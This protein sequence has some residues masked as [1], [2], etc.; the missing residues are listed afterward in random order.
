MNTIVKMLFGSHL[1]GTDTPESD[2]DYKGVFLPSREQVLL[3]RIPEV[4]SSST[5]KGSGKNTS[6]DVDIEMFSLHRFIDM[7]CQG[8]TVAIDMLHAPE[9]FWRDATWVW[10]EIVVNR[11]RFYTSNMSAFVQYARRQA[12]KYGIKGSRL[13]DAKRVY[14]VLGSYSGVRVADI[15]KLLPVGGHIHKYESEKPWIYEVCGRKIQETVAISYAR[16]IIGKFIRNYGERARQAECNEGVDW[17]AVSHALRAAYQVWQILVEGTITFPL[18]KAPYLKKVKAGEL[19]YSTE[20]APELDRMVT[21][22]EELSEKSTL[23]KQV[24]REWWDRF[25]MDVVEKNVLFGR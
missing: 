24:D 1:Y 14:D 19:D 13:A 15:W 2:V 11:S 7:A 3:G 10:P 18:D 21:E 5:K 22:I 8:Q 25:V 16:D 17:K 12:S 4:V 9:S 6:A 20:V 23:P